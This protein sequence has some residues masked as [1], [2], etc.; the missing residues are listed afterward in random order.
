[1]KSLIINILQ[2]CVF[3]GN[4]HKYVVNQYFDK[5]SF[6]NGRWQD[7]WNGLFSKFSF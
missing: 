6:S 2:M 7:M 3:G 5:L 4:D 1:M